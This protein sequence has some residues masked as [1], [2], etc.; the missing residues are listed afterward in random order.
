MLQLLKRNH[1]RQ[2]KEVQNK[3]NSEN[4]QLVFLIFKKKN[5]E[6]HGVDDI[7]SSL[8]RHCQTVLANQVKNI[9][10]IAWLDEA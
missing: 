7:S 6:N 4:R 1:G 8:Q 9:E 10:G 2:L 3:T 5:Q